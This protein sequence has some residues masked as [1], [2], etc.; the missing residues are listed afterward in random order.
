MNDCPCGSGTALAECCEPYINGTAP[1]PTAEALMRARYTAHTQG[2]MD[3]LVSSH[4]E[5]TRGE[6]D[7]ELTRR[8]AERCDWLGLEITATEQ[9]AAG[10]TAGVV[11]FVAHYRDRDERHQ[12]RERALFDCVDGAWLY[13]D[14][15]A[16][17]IETARRQQPKVGRNEPCPCG[18]GKKYK[19]CCGKA[20]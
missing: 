7:I 1:A 2:N 18:S 8:W 5:D 16:P 3:F 20:A 11:E 12:H 13:R 6:I 19:K 14:A 10:D 17:Q 15:E 4:V 9:G